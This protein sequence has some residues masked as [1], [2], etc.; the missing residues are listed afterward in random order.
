[1]K[2]DSI[3]RQAAIQPEQQ[4]G[5]VFKGIVVEYPSYNTYPEY[6]GKPYFSIKY[7]ENGQEFIGYGTYKPE[8]LSE[9]LKEY[10]MPSAQPEPSTEIQEILDYL[11][12]TL[13]P[14]V[15]PDNWNVYSELHDMVSK[16]PSVQPERGTGA[17][18]INDE[19]PQHCWCSECNNFFSL[20]DPKSIHFCPNCGSEM[21]TCVWKS[22]YEKEN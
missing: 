18:I 6:I 8:V 3:S 16:L 19:Y 17:W 22:Q 1:M 14:I 15:S 2:D 9:Y 11:D 12:N 21:K 7:T 10:F 20:F 4:H 13:H 5:R